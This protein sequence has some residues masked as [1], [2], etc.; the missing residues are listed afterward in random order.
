MCVGFFLVWCL[1]FVYLCSVNEVLP[2]SRAGLIAF[3]LIRVHKWFLN[4]S[5]VSK[6]LKFLHRFSCFESNFSLS[7]NL[8]LFHL[9]F[10]SWLYSSV[11]RTLTGNVLFPFPTELVSVIW[12]C[13]LNL[14]Y[15][16]TADVP[17]PPPTC[18]T[19]KIFTFPIK[20]SWQLICCQL[21][22][23]LL[24]ILCRTTLVKWLTDCFVKPLCAKDKQ[25]PR[26]F[27]CTCY[28]WRIAGI[29]CGISLNL[30]I[31]LF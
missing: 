11:K 4:V 16:Q 18:I 27:I 3:S 13:Y 21:L 7:F 12:S 23:A 5:N 29:I 14:K 8:I 20:Y 25:S 17:P 10:Y 1:C 2:D 31:I 22:T 15:V 30:V 28:I 9:L 6:I 19:D 24:C 26:L